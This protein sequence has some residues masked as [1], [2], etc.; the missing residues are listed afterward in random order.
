MDDKK[1]DDNPAGDD[2]L[3]AHP[4][5]AGART[6]PPP[7]LDDDR[8]SLPPLPHPVPHAGHDKR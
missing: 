2:G 7:P 8:H 6:T 5:H 3:G 4:Q 1:E